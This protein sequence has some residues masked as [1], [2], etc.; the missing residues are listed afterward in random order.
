[1]FDKAFFFLDI[2]NTINPPGQGQH[3]FIVVCTPEQGIAIDGSHGQCIIAPVK[4]CC[5]K[6]T[7]DLLRKSCSYCVFPEYNLIG[8]WIAEAN[9][10]VLQIARGAG[11]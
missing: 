5:Y 11:C 6:N 2:C 4:S 10:S 3:D 8:F 7:V 9:Q 1:M